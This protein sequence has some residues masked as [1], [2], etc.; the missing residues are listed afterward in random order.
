M[1]SLFILL[2]LY[3]GAALAH[4]GAKDAQGCHA[5][6]KVKG[7]VHCHRPPPAASDSF[8]L[9]EPPVTQDKGIDPSCIDG[10]R[11]TRYKIVNGQKKVC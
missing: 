4:P 9:T 3:S 2:A 8:K 7:E 5:N 10:P 1:K 6:K 11:G